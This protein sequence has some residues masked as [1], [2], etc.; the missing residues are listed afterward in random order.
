MSQ[1][2]DHTTDM[3][4]N[5]AKAQAEIDK[6]EAEANAADTK[7]EKPAAKTQQVNG[8]ASAEPE[9][10]QEEDAS[11]DVVAEIADASLEDKIAEGTA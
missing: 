2:L 8:S 3:L 10:K 11:N 4:Q 1:H 5:I 7:A 6:L 9:S